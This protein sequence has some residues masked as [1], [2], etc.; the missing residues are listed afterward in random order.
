MKKVCILTSEMGLG[1]YIA[2]VNLR[3]TILEKDEGTVCDLL[4]YEILMPKEKRERLPQYRQAFHNDKRLAV[5]GHLM[6]NKFENNQDEEAILDLYKKWDD[7][8]YNKFVVMSGNWLPIIEGYGVNEDKV[9]CIRLD[10]SPTVT[11]LKYDYSEKLFETIWILGKDDKEPNFV[12]YKDLNPLAI[13][14]RIKQ[15]FVHGGGW[16]MGNYLEILGD[17]VKKIKTVTLAYDPKD[18]V[19][20]DL[21]NTYL[22]LDSDWKA[23]SEDIFPVLHEIDDFGN[24]GQSKINGIDIMKASVAVVS[25]PGGGTIIDSLATLTPMVYLDPISKHEQTNL[26]FYLNRGLGLS[27]KG[28]MSAEN[29]I[30]EFKRVQDKL[31]KYIFSK[32]MIADYIL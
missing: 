21:N 8:G 18:C 29:L 2:A 4:M 24:V 20:K 9:I 14:E 1:A 17:L 12:L 23:G 26:D 27:L 6:M 10:C 25:K 28:A 32:H 11:W 31:E 16:G 7:I 30:D 19:L 5:A 3:R 22:L 13:T 15:V